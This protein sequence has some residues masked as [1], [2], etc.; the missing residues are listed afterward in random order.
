MQLMDRSATSRGRAAG[1]R[2]KQTGLLQ[3]VA[4][5]VGRR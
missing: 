2:E 5:M 1:G 3:T 4:Q